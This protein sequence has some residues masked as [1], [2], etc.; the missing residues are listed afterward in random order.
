VSPLSRNLLHNAATAAA[1]AAA[2][3]AATAGLTFPNEQIKRAHRLPPIAY[4]AAA[5]TQHSV[6]MASRGVRR[7]EFS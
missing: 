6:N 4:D 2:A 1:A 3:A 7:A 5:S